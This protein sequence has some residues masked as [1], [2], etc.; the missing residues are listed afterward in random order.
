MN[1][2]HQQ[3]K[4]SFVQVERFNPHDVNDLNNH[5]PT[6]TQRFDEMINFCKKIIFN[7]DVK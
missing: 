7:K 3:Y 4:V 6:N 2:W 5:K 1:I